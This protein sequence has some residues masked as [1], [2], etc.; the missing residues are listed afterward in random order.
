MIKTRKFKL[1]PAI[2]FQLY[3]QM[4]LKK[5]VVI[6]LC[7]LPIFIL[8]FIQ[9]R[10]KGFDVATPIVIYLLGLISVISQAIRAKNTYNSKLNGA[11]FR[12]REII[13]DAGKISQR[14]EDGIYSEIPIKLFYKTGNRKD[15][16]LLYI[17]TTQYQWIPKDAFENESDLMEFEKLL[18]IQPYK[19]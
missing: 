17:V 1:T 7:L 2:Q 10:T 14:S 11:L 9:S 3:K 12:E 13:I 6:L 15:C 19:A 5:Q 18:N 4:I 16:Y 8:S